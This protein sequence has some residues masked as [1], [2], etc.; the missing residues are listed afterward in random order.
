MFVERKEKSRNAARNRRN[1]ENYEF[2]A[3]AKIIP[4][5]FEISSQLDKASIVRLIISLMKLKIFMS[6]DDIDRKRVKYSCIYSLK[7]KY[8]TKDFA[9]FNCKSQGLQG[10]FS[11]NPKISLLGDI[12]K[13]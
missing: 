10:I 6:H 9:S 13:K 8:L 4:I 7:Y 12:S 5:P 3:L 1:K 2:E 11:T